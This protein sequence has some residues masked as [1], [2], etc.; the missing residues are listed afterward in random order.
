V[1]H[2]AVVAAGLGKAGAAV[3]SREVLLGVGAAAAGRGA[4]RIQTTGGRGLRRRR[5]E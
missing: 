5:A 4:G 3:E 2:L 1:G